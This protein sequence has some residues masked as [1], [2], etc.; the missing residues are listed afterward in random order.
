MPGLGYGRAMSASLLADEPIR[1]R[2]VKEY[3][4]LAE[5]GA[6]DDERVELLHG[7]IVRMLPQ[8][9]RDAAV[10]VKLTRLFA[11]HLGDDVELRVQLP[12]ETDEYGEPE[13]DFALC[14]PRPDLEQSHPTTADLVVE[15]SDSTRKR[16][17]VTKPPLYAQAG[18]REYWVIDLQRRVVHGRGHPSARLNMAVA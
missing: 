16:D 9:P 8:G 5:L 12:L 6:F 10:I 13:P 15:V 11:R 17:L 14:A 3:H 4:Q 2:S 18:V 7:V 1:R